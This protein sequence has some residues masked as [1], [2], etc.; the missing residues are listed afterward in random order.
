[1]KTK[2]TD[3]NPN[4]IADYLVSVSEAVE[5]ESENNAIEVY[6]NDMNESQQN[7]I[8]HLLIYMAPCC[9]IH[10][11]DSS[12][13]D[14]IFAL[15][16]LRGYI[17]YIASWLRIEQGIGKAIKKN[18]D[19]LKNNANFSFV[20]ACI[21]LILDSYMTGLVKYHSCSF[22]DTVTTTLSRL[23]IDENLPEWFG[24]VDSVGNQLKQLGN[25][26]VNTPKLQCQLAEQHIKYQRLRSENDQIKKKLEESDTIKR[27]TVKRLECEKKDL[28]NKIGVTSDYLETVRREYELRIRKLEEERD[29]LQDKVEVL[30]MQVEQQDELLSHE[31]LPPNEAID[32]DI[33]NMRV[34]VVGGREN[35]LQKIQKRFPI[36]NV[37]GD[38]LNSFKPT[39]LDVVVYYPRHC[40]HKLLI[41]G[42]KIAVA[43]NALEVFVSSVNPDMLEEEIQLKLHNL[44]SL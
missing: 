41:Q 13:E 34:L 5:R 38:D 16:N 23:N 30:N 40:S 29:A 44:I 15:S 8:R 14:I 31:H 18:P 35:F 11:P 28:Q 6:L 10:I 22:V 33:A 2:S 25:Y 42:R 17:N 27:L 43:T 7:Y 21:Y 9:N 24:K 20:F 39:K 26:A 37:P 36:W 1:M 19:F 3:F 4:E 32:L 12:S